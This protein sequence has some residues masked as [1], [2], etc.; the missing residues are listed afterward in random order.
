MKIRVSERHTKLRPAVR[1]N[2]I[3]KLEGLE[4]YC[5]RI[6]SIDGIVEEE[7]DHHIARLVAHLVRKKIVKAEAQSQ[8]LHLAINEAVDNL[9]SQLSRYNDQLKDHRTNAALQR[10]G[11]TTA[12]GA[13]EFEY[14][15]SVKRNTVL[16]TEVHLRKPMTVE[17][18]LLQLDAYNRDLFLFEDAG[19]GG[20]RILHRHADGQIEL[21]EPKY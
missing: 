17:E 18:A 7:K 2:L 1:Q 15:E 4:R 19:G 20:L 16:R 10:S 13:L 3:E 8:D 12:E 11:P 14:D 5:D 6:I 21:L 9:K